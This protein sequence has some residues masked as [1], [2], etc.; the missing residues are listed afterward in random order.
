MAVCPN[1]HVEPVRVLLRK[2]RGEGKVPQN[3]GRR[4]D[5][6]KLSDSREREVPPVVAG[7]P[8]VETRLAIALRVG[9]AYAGGR[10]RIEKEVLS[11]ADASPFIL[12]AP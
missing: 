7:G 11:N 12:F 4:S 6:L 2:G 9:R 10:S 1:L 3:I 8:S 5:D